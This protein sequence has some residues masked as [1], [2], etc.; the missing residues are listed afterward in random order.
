MRQ[1]GHNAKWLA[2]TAGRLLVRRLL[3]LPGLLRGWPL[4]ILATVAF[5][6][7]SMIQRDR[8]FSAV[9]GYATVLE[10]L[11]GNT[12]AGPQYR[13]YYH[14]DG[15]AVGKV[16]SQYDSGY[17]IARDDGYCENWRTWG[18]GEVL[19]WTLERRDRTLIRRGTTTPRYLDRPVSNRLTIEAGNTLDLVILPDAPGVPEPSPLPEA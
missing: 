15:R 9:T 19:C 14:T 3:Q 8:G 11:Q 1:P 10:M 4:V 2:S 16:G 5:T 7:V 17:W 12:L 18:D 13:F 6:L